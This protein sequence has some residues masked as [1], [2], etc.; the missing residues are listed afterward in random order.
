MSRPKNTNRFRDCSNKRRF[1]E[2]TNSTIPD[3]I[4]F[5]I[6]DTVQFFDADNPNTSQELMLA[7][8]Q[9]EPAGEYDEAIAMY[10]EI[11]QDTASGNSS[12][13]ACLPRVLNRIIQ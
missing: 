5:G 7:A 2:A 10:K 13:P 8:Y 1:R 6:Y 11:I 12:A 4:G 9:S 3:S